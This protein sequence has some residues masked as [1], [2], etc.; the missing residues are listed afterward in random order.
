MMFLMDEPLAAALVRR[1][2]GPEDQATSGRSIA[3]IANELIDDF[4]FPHDFLLFFEFFAPSRR[5]FDLISQ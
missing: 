5:S 1:S 4:A 3:Q 2:T